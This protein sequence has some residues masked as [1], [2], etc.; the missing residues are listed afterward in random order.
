[1]VGV[2]LHSGN[3]DGGFLSPNRNRDVRASHQV[4]PSAPKRPQL[5]CKL[6]GSRRSVRK[7][8]RLCG[9]CRTAKANWDLAKRYVRKNKLRPLDSDIRSDSDEERQHRL[10]ARQARR[11]LDG[12][13][14]KTVPDVKAKSKTG[15]APASSTPERNKAIRRWATK[16]GYQMSARGRIS[17][18]VKNAFAQA[19][20]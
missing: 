16:N 2:R 17:A 3:P 4:L 19:Q 13:K 14:R 12:N 5:S 10:V 8:P 18:E 11:R 15:N 9:S 7:S 1:M 6:C 20:E